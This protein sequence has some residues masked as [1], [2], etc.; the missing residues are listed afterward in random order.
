MSEEDKP[1]MDDMSGVI[2]LDTNGGY[3]NTPS[4]AS[5]FSTCNSV[6]CGTVGP[7]IDDAL[8]NAVRNHGNDKSIRIRYGTAYFCEDGSLV[9]ECTLPFGNNVYMMIDEGDAMRNCDEAMKAMEEM[10]EELSRMQEKVF[11]L[12]LRQR[13]NDD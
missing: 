7:G 8:K 2:V 12:S 11:E 13:R 6:S 4:M 10:K 1:T 5:V 9:M 3:A